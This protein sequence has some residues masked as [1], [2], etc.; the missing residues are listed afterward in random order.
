MTSKTD[1][2]Q[3]PRAIACRI[4]SRSLIWL[5]CLGLC[6]GAPLLIQVTLDVSFPWWSY[7][8]FLAGA[9]LAYLKLRDDWNESKR[10]ESGADGEDRV[11]DV[12]QTLPQNWHI[13]RN[14]R[15][16]GLGDIDFFVKSPEGRAFTI[17]A[18]A[19]G[20]KVTESGG[21]LKRVIRG[22]EKEFE[23]DLLSQ[24]T[25]QAIYMHNNRHPGFVT[26]ILVFTKAKVTL[27][28]RFVRNVHILELGELK[29]FL[30]YTTNL[31][32]MTGRR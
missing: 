11:W 23:K 19:H 28:D 10:Y 22:K 31:P 5:V 26:A 12:L 18:K 32:A 9:R 16:V 7:C 15:A 4:Q 1:Y 27:Q 2:L 25:R 24:A 29:D 20:G 13:E 30:S 8:F 21:I 3:T 6:F 14:I 17:D